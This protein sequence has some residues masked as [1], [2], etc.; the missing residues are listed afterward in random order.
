MVKEME[1]YQLNTYVYEY[2]FIIFSKK[3]AMYFNS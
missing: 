2:K 1:V 3:I